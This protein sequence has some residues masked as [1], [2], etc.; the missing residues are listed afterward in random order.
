LPETLPRS[1]VPVVLR[2]MDMGETVDLF[3][4]LQGPPAS[5]LEFLL[6]NIS[7]RLADQIKE[8]LSDHSGLSAEDGEISQR[9]FLMRIM[10]LKRSG[11]IAS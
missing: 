10:A 6:S 11:D 9:N 5:V 8:K 1:A 3:S 4:T 2:E 7:S